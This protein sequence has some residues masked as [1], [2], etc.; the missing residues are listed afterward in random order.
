MTRDY[1]QATV[2][3]LE[4]ANEELAT[5]NEELH[6]RMS[7]LA[8][9]NDDLHNILATTRAPVLIIGMDQVQQAL[10]GHHGR[11]LRVSARRIAA[12]G[13]RAEWTLVIF[14]ETGAGGDDA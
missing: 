10:G 13:E 11:R 5:V 7:Q 6:N 9:S 14:D 4:T 1:L 3:D 2:R 8:V 12:D